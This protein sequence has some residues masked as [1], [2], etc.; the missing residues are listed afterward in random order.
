MY[1]L[2]VIIFMHFLSS[3]HILYAYWIDRRIAFFSAIYIYFYRV[4]KATDTIKF[5]V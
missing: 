5:I 3:A 4:S 2:F 1:A